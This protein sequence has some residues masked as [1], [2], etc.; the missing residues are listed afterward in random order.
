MTVS[1]SFSFGCSSQSE[2]YKRTGVLSKQMDMLIDLSA[3]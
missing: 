2:W 3:A 1:T